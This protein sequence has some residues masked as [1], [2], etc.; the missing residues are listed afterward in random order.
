MRDIIHKNLFLHNLLL[1]V[2][3]SI[4]SI[5]GCNNS[6][7]TEGNTV[8]REPTFVMAPNAHTP[9]AGLL[10]VSTSGLSRISV[11]ISDGNEQFTHDYEGFNTEHSL[12][13]LGFKPSRIY[14][15]TVRILDIDGIDLIEPTIFQAITRSLPEGFPEINVTSTPELMEPG[16][17]L[18]EAANYLVAVDATGEVCWYHFIQLPSG[19]LDRDVRRMK[20]GNLLLMLARFRTVELDMLGNIVN[21][22]HPSQ[23]TDGDPGSIPVDT[24]AFHHEVFEMESGNLL[25]LSVEFETFFD[26]P[27]SVSPIA[28]LGEAI[29]V[30][31]VVVEFTPDGTIVN[32]WSMLDLLDPYR[33]NYSSWLG[34]YNNLYEMVFGVAEPTADWS[35]GNAVI[36]D[37]SDD[38]II[39]SFRHQDAVVKFSRQTGELIWILGPHENWDPERFGKYLLTPQSEHEFFFPYHQHAPD[40]TDEGTILIYDNGNNR[41]SP[42]DPTL[43]DADNFSRAVEYKINEETKEIDIVWEYG[44]FEDETL[45]TFFIG[46]ADYLPLTGNALITF[47]GTQPARLIEVTRTT[48]AVKVFDLSLPGNFTYRSERLDSL[49]P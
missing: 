46:D 3:I 22:W 41:A 11:T 14:T 34:L 49:Y 2:A 5:S 29:V 10:E 48:P 38:S 27:T 37:P 17:T 43:S 39:V 21:L 19:S 8:T 15:I 23:S 36:H 7:N 45:Y 25:M 16:V 20:N 4:F 35:H 28:A 24:L 32:E 18:F 42:F 1:I 12:P 33:L 40:V 9:L 6:S 47:G 30:G 44:Q 31:D 26:Y 13:V